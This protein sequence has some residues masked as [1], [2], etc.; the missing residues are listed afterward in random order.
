MSIWNWAFSTNPR[1]HP[2]IYSFLAALL[3]WLATLGLAGGSGALGSIQA[4]MSFAMFFVIVGLGQMFV[5]ASGPG[6]IDLSVP[7]VMTLSGLIG[8]MVMNQSAGLILPGLAVAIATGLAVGF[9]NFNLIRVLRIPPIVATL[10]MSFVVESIAIHASGAATI[11]PPDLLT[12]ITVLRIF[13]IPLLPLVMVGVSAAVIMV[14]RRTLFG[15]Y[16]LAVGQNETAAW[17]ANVDPNRIRLFVYV[18]CGGCASLAGVLLAGFSSGASLD[19]GSE[20]QLASIAVVVVGGTSVMGGRAFPQGIWG[21]S[22]FLYVLVNLLNV[23]SVR[24]GLGS[25]GSGIRFILTGLIIVLV[26]AVSRDDD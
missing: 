19:M 24:F 4:A 23:A 22:L 17:L 14:L 2:W 25:A 5:I 10:A 8:M 7:G 21:A 20:Y 15:R 12:T 11:K 3:I 1:K 26:V 18:I 13:G 6:N 16:V 9:V